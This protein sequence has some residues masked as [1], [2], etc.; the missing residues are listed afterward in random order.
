MDVN[1]EL[2]H[3]LWQI[4]HRKHVPH[5]AAAEV[6]HERVLN[7]EGVLGKT[8]R[9]LKWILSFNIL[10]ANQVSF[11]V[12]RLNYASLSSLFAYIFIKHWDFE[13]MLWM[14][15]VWKPFLVKIK[16]VD[17]HLV[18]IC[19][20]VLPWK[21]VVNF[22]RVGC[23]LHPLIFEVSVKVVHLEIPRFIRFAPSALNLGGSL[24]L[25]EVASYTKLILCSDKRRVNLGAVI[26]Y[27]T[28]FFV[29]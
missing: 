20:A 21:V 26:P 4:G 16:S 17:D 13:R 3:V 12:S 5:R 24:C 1:E 2:R 22:D 11:S 9:N 19:F 29:I 25:S 8:L 6:H 18:L 15:S 7:C 27:F 28:S 14:D 10:S 23:G